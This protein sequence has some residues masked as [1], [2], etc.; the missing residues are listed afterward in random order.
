MYFL[1]GGRPRQLVPTRVLRE[2]ATAQAALPDWLFE[3]SYQ[4]VGD[5]AETI[6]LLVPVHADGSNEGLATW[7]EQYLLPLRG[8]RLSRFSSACSHCGRSWTAPA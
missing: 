4:A 2:Q 6:S 7:V 1:A 5:L 8:Y 3:E